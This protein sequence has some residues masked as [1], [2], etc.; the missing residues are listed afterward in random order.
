MDYTPSL[1]DY[2]R[3]YQNEISNLD[4]LPI[5]KNKSSHLE[6]EDSDDENVYQINLK[7]SKEEIN[8]IIK[9]KFNEINDNFNYLM[10][11]MEE[12]KISPTDLFKSKT[13]GYVI[14]SEQKKNLVC[15]LS[16]LYGKDII[17]KNF[18]ITKKKYK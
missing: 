17:S 13:E 18:N 11:K 15:E 4:F 10:K 1:E 7:S 12:Y 14:Y 5:F 16:K 8:K 3:D 2:K 9:N 6:I